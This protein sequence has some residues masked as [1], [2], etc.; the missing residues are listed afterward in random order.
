MSHNVPKLVYGTIPTAI[1]FT[2]PPVAKG[3][4]DPESYVSKDHTN[5]SL[6]GVRQTSVDY[7]QA[8]NTVVLSHLSEAQ[9]QAIA[10]FFKTWG[11]LGKSFQ[12]YEDQNSA[13]FVTYELNKL[14]FAAKRIAAVSANN[15]LYEITLSFRRTLGV[16]SGTVVMSLAI[17]NNQAAPVDL[18]GVLLDSTVS[19]TVTIFFELVRKTDSNEIVAA[20][21]LRA[22]YH[23]LTGLWDITPIGEYDGDA[24]G[25][26]F[27]MNGNQVQYTSSPLSGTNYV[28]TLKIQNLILA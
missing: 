23:A 27:S 25:V 22:T 7:V 15:Y 12:Y 18:T 17:L 4:N 3:G 24:T 9:Y 6:A 19:Q 1:V 16:G 10:T 13:S 2:Y 21:I 20:G 26:T 8:E 28:G 14:A 11:Y 5:F